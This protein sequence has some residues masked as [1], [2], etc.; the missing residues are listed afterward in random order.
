M[1]RNVLNSTDI[2]YLFEDNPAP[3][4]D[5]GDWNISETEMDLSV[6]HKPEI[7]AYNYM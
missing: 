6:I 1:L 2:M 5:Y 7:Y 3:V 4:K